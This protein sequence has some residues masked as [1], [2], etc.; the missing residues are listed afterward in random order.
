MVNQKHFT[1]RYRGNRFILDRDKKTIGGYHGRRSVK[2]EIT[3]NGT[4][5][6]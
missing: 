5:A 4:Y 1:Y 2:K 3:K 6:G